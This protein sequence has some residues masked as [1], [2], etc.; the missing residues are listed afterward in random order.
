MKKTLLTLATLC[1]VSAQGLFAQERIVRG[2][3]IGDN[4]NPLSDAMITVVGNDAYFALTDENGNYELSVPADASGLKISYEGYGEKTI[5]ISDQEVTTTLSTVQEVLKEIEFSTPYGGRSGIASKLNFVGSV[6]RVDAKKIEKRPITNAASALEGNVSGLLVAKTSGQPGAGPQVRIRGFSSISGNSEPLYVVDGSVFMGNI[7]SLNSNDI[8]AIDVLKDATAT[9]L[10]GSRGANGV[11]LITTKSGKSAQ[12]P[13]VNVDAK[14]GAITRAIPNYNVLKDPGQYLE[15]AWDAYRNQMNTND[16]SVL[17][18]NEYRLKR[19][20]KSVIDNLGYNPYNVAAENLFD[21]QGRLNPDAQLLYK[22]DWDKEIQRLGLRQEYNVNAMGSSNGSDYYLSLGYLNEKGYV[23][24]SDYERISG[25]VSVNNKL[26]DWLKVGLNLSGS[27]STSNSISSNSTAGGY[28]PFFVSRNF[29]PIY[30]VYYY[31]QQGNRE[32]DPYTGD[33]KY[34]WGL[35]SPANINSPMSNSSI[36]TRGNLRGA[37]VL[38][39]MQLDEHKSHLF[40]LIAVPYL[41]AQFLKYFTFKTDVNYNFG[42]SSGL[43]YYNKY[44]GQYYERGGYISRDKLDYNTFTWKKLLSFDHSIKNK[45]EK[46]HNFNVIAGHEVYSMGRNVLYADRSGLPTDQV[47]DLNG[48]AIAVSSGSYTD[49]DKMESYLG[50]FNYNFDS[51]YFFN[52][53][54]RRDGSSRFPANNRWGN[55]WSVGGGW[56]IS[57][58]AFMEKYSNIDLLKVKASYGTQGNNGTAYYGYQSLAN[59]NYANGTAPG[60]IVSQVGNPNLTWESQNLFNAG[61]EFGFSKRL[62]GELTYYSKVNADQL[63][64]RPFP[65]STGVGS[66]LENVMTSVNS[67]I[68]GQLSYDI[69]TPD[70][71]SGVYWNVTVNGATQNNRIT[72]MPEGSDSLINGNFI[73][74]KGYSMYTYYLVHSAGVDEATG[75]ELYRYSKDGVTIDTSSY[76]EANAT[77]RTY[78]KKRVGYDKFFGS[79]TNTLSYK[80]FDFSFMLTFGLGG[81][82]YDGEYQDLMGN[83]LSYGNNVHEDWL[84]DRWTLDNTTGTLPKAEFSNLEISGASDRFLVSRN[85]LNIT[86][87]NLGYTFNRSVLGNSFRS[88]RLY[89]SCDNVWVFAARKGMNPQATFGGNMS[90]GNAYAYPASRGFI[91]GVNI[92]L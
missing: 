34:D 50:A 31:D 75:N 30:P 70:Q 13:Q 40:S 11:V 65:T 8:A 48:S 21:A 52:A 63:Y 61:V 32:L 41:E 69:L 82:Y 55:F 68:D 66:R 72:K 79:F 19:F 17:P 51:K 5:K 85:Y 2:T 92:G 15:F 4:G 64:S 76:S 16:K 54:F 44:Y 10:Y 39:A 59:I 58:E 28:N 38:G 37:N 22:D 43:D 88:L 46:S 90:G 26:N 47:R 60:A 62:R 33:Y 56:I 9:S 81:K 7:A 80:G 18:T 87:I 35:V 77:G 53:N 27:Y 78:D 42:N 3:V 91:F 67:G 24:Y 1:L 20:N 45:D 86:N 36:G 29:A 6:E 49:E 71:A 83:G 23:K 73:Y 84:K 14:V 25:R 74:K 89:L 57:N 12:K